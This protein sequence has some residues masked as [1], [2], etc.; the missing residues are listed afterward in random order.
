MPSEKVII[1]EFRTGITTQKNDDG[2]FLANSFTGYY[3]DFTLNPIPLSVQQAISNNLFKVAEG[4]S[5]DKP[6]IIGRVVK[7]TTFNDDPDYSVVAIVSRGTDSNGRTATLTRFFL[8]EGANSLPKILYFLEDYK[9]KHNQQYPV[10]N[11]QE[12]RK[13]GECHQMDGFDSAPHDPKLTI[14]NQWQNQLPNMPILLNPN[15]ENYSLQKIHS[16]AK[17]RAAEIH[18][19]TDI[20][21]AYNVEALE[22]PLSFIVIHPTNLPAY[23]RIHIAINNYMN[24]SPSVAAKE[25]RYKLAIQNLIEHSNVNQESVK[26]IIE[27]LRDNDITDLDWQRWFNGQ[28]ADTINQLTPGDR[29]ERLLM[30]QAMILP[31]TLP[32][33][34]KWII[35]REKHQFNNM[36][37]GMGGLFYQ[38]KNI[39]Q[40]MIDFQNQFINII[41]NNGSP[42][43]IL[44]GIK[45][46]LIE[47]KKKTIEVKD[48]I[49]FLQNDVGQKW[50]QCLQQE[51]TQYILSDLKLIP[52]LRPGASAIIQNHKYPESPKFQFDVINLWKEI[53]MNWK[54]ISPSNSSSG[55]TP[56]KI[57]FEVL[58]KYKYL[59]QLFEQLQTDPS[60]QKDNYRLAAY[61]YQISEGIVSAKVFENAYGKKI[62]EYA[63]PELKLTIK[64]DRSL[65]E[66]LNYYG[67]KYWLAHFLL[68]NVIIWGLLWYIFFRNIPVQVTS[69]TENSS[70]SVP[71]KKENLTSVKTPDSSKKQLTNIPEDINNFD[72]ET[73]PAIA[74]IKKL[75]CTSI[76]P[77]CPGKNQPNIDKIINQAIKEVLGNSN[78]PDYN[79]RN[80]TE[81]DIKIKQQWIQQIKDY[82]QNV[83]NPTGK[84]IVDGVITN[85]PTFNTF[86]KL[87]QQT[88][89]KVKEKLQ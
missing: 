13:L 65:V 48:A 84:N 51:A 26:I 35:K 69:N 56:P 57:N 44:T 64:R 66:N 86:N 11:P 68:Q 39:N 61:F 29:W 18:P 45:Y 12:S 46:L 20:A 33:F 74:E 59:A 63:D 77:R 67:K 14:P 72:K 28:G 22:N 73:V 23:D 85:N 53:I 27:G 8:C 89:E 19:S 31:A 49:I 5:R 75:V 71:T 37:F 47:L 38:S 79:I 81:E 7:K 36:F 17:L 87:K 62:L 83:I 34:I 60:P 40:P 55:K 58:S 32:A 43:L 82:Q 3:M 78:L 41:I 88:E 2:G 9:S 1:H 4:S 24:V 50:K 16:I 25:G 30:L 52:D 21:W 70:S 54:Q 76:K 42:N 80:T 10:F 6:A 15:S